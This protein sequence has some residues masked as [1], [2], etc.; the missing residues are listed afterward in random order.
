M[1]KLQIQSLLDPP[2]IQDSCQKTVLFFNSQSF[3]ELDEL[4]SLVLE[5]KKRKEDLQIN[6]RS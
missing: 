5:A 1:I 4:E 2:N 6:V 3:D